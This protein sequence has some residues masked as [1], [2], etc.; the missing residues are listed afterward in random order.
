[1]LLNGLVPT[2]ISSESNHPSP[3]ESLSIVA[4]AV[5]KDMAITNDAIIF[6]FFHVYFSFLIY[7]R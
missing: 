1:M 6:L 2:K 7:T 5:I 4:F 3:S